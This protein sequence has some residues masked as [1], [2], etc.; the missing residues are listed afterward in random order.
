MRILCSAKDVGAY[1]QIEAFIDLCLQKEKNFSYIIFVEN[2]AYSIAKLGNKKIYKVSFENIKIKFL[3]FFFKNFSPNFVLTGVSAFGSGVDDIFRK[4]AKKN[5]IPSGA[6]QDYWGYI[7]GYLGKKTIIQLPDFFFVIDQ[8]AK[9]LTLSRISKKSKSKVIVTGSPKHFLYKKKIKNWKLTN[10]NKKKSIHIFM[11]TFNVPGILE[12]YETLI[13]I[14]LPFDKACKIFIH[15]HPSDNTKKSISMP[16]KYNLKYYTS[17]NF[18][19]EKSLI[20]ADLVLTFFSTIGLDHNYLYSFSNKKIGE[21]IYI[22]IGSKMKNWINKITGVPKVPGSIK[23]LGITVNTK[24]EL[25][26]K[27]KNFIDGKKLN[28][29][30]NLSA[31]KLS[32]NFSPCHKIIDTIKLTQKI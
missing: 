26:R 15:K 29:Y 12:N 13:K 31:K 9:K 1:K 2:P 30:S 28:T 7:G 3:E 6:I 14:L 5:K 27:I 10:N 17:K 4:I 23:K 25:N 32:I 19:L 11:Q 18:T 22:N 20:N 24:K 16:N 8:L 21:L